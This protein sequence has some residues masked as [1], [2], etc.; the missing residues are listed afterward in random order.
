M[1]AEENRPVDKAADHLHNYPDFKRDFAKGFFLGEAEGTYYFWDHGSITEFKGEYHVA[2]NVSNYFSG[3]VVG[4]N[5]IRYYPPKMV[6]EAF[7]REQTV[8]ALDEEAEALELRADFPFTAEVLCL[9]TLRRVEE[10]LPLSEGLNGWH[11]FVV[12]LEALASANKGKIVQMEGIDHYLFISEESLVLQFATADDIHT[13]R[14]KFG[15]TMPEADKESPICSLCDTKF[16][17]CECY[18]IKGFKVSK[19]L[20]IKMI[21]RQK[22]SV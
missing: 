17:A 8:E 5:G 6:L 12:R 15:P 16:E 10:R 4:S 9:E 3:P 19:K 21:E 18:D 20:L 13:F 14:W 7:K 11:H 22:F 2:N 1:N